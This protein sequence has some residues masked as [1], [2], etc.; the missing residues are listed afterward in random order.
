MAA[1]A[2]CGFMVAESDFLVDDGLSDRPRLRLVI[3]RLGGFK[4]FEEIAQ[5]WTPTS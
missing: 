3:P 1:V 2:C 5:F 4:V